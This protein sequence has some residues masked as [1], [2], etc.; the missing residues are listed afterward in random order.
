MG[1]GFEQMKE[2]ADRGFTSTKR[3]KDLEKTVKATE[4][5]CYLCGGFVNVNIPRFL[6]DDEGEFYKDAETGKKKVNPEAPEIEHVIP[7]IHG[8]DPLSRD[9]VRLVHAI[10]NNR[11]GDRFLSEIDMK[12]F[13]SPNIDLL[14]SERKGRK[15]TWQE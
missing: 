15:R 6:V 4:D 9:N 14:K 5:H 11:K 1:R 13:V 12:S 10:C 7:I 8:G 2:L 3:W